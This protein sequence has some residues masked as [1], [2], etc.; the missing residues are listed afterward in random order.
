MLTTKLHLFLALISLIGAVTTYLIWRKNDA[1]KK[2]MGYFGLFFLMFIFYNLC[3]SLPFIVSGGNLEY[4]T[5]GYNLATFFVFLFIAPM[6]N[7]IIYRLLLIKF[8]NAKLLSLVFVIIGLAVFVA[9]TSDFRLPIITQHG[10][11]LWNNNFITGF[12]TMFFAALT[13]LLWIVTYFH[14]RPAEI[15]VREKVKVFLFMLGTIAFALSSIYFIAGNVIL[16]I[17]AFVFVYSGSILFNITI[18]LSEKK[19]SIKN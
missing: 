4:M 11:V 10:L 19:I 3:L 12:V 2:S 1:R 9:Q 16:V 7:V 17:A 6:Y 15:S 13:A 14:N 8:G 18:F 5:W